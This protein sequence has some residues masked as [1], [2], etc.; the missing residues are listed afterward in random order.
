MHYILTHRMSERRFKGKFDER[1]FELR[2]IMTAL[3]SGLREREDD[4]NRQARNQSETM[5][6]TQTTETMVT[7]TREELHGV[8]ELILNS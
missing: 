8:E 4:L 5:K 6:Q 2:G 7:N 3:N 1:K